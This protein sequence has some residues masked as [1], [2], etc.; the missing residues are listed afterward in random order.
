MSKILKNFSYSRDGID[1][2]DALVD[3]THDIPDDLVSGLKDEGFI[4][5]ASGSKTTEI[6]TPTGDANDPK[7]FDIPDDWEDGS[8]DEIIA[9]ATSIT[10][11]DY[12]D[13]RVAK[14]D[15]EVQIE[16]NASLKVTG[17]V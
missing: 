16:I 8:R 1:T 3:E 6:K 14:K 10:G 13:V 11:E 12:S 9:L 5:E 15:I 2:H 17:V 7:P 4:S